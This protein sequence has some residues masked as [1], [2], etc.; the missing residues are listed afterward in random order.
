[1]WE[2]GRRKKVARWLEEEAVW[3]CLRKRW[4]GNDLDSL[5]GTSWYEERSLCYYL[6]ASSEQGKAT[7]A[8]THTHTR[9]ILEGDVAL[10]FARRREGVGVLPL[11]FVYWR[12]DMAKPR[13][14]S[15]LGLH[16]S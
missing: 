6:Q 7:A 15:Y 8:H 1:M 4:R 3:W 2:K 11:P 10:C 9:G 14:G 16:F 13:V 5:D 12:I